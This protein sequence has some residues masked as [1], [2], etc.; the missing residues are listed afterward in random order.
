MAGELDAQLRRIT[1]NVT[2]ELID[3]AIPLDSS[4]CMIADAIKVA[5]PE[6]RSVIVDLAA[7]RWT[8][9]K[10]GKRY[11]YFTPGSVQDVLLQ[12]DNGTKPQPFRFV[13]RAPAQVTN[14]GPD[15]I[16]RGGRVTQ[17]FVNVTGDSRDSSTKIGGTAPGLGPLSNMP[18]TPE[19]QRGARQQADMPEP[20]EHTETVQLEPPKTYSNR[21]Q[22]FERSGD[23]M[24]GR[25]RQFGI[26][27]MGRPKLE[28]GE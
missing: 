16:K 22:R 19:S 14:S 9:S 17:G 24:R 27:R 8:N 20:H 18:A 15:K 28:L 5:V 6:A 2:E 11:I 25:R 3:A 12:F 7:I 23:E 4:H 1:V 13:L 21:G 26:R 10:E